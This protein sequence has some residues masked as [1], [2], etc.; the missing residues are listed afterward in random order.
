MRL[1]RRAGSLFVLV[2]LLC[3]LAKAMQVP[4][5]SVIVVDQTNAVVPG[6]TVVLTSTEDQGAAMFVTDS[7]GAVQFPV[8]SGTYAL[9]VKARGFAPV[10]KRVYVGAQAQSERVVLPVGA[11]GGVEVT[12]IA[13]PM[14]VQSANDERL[15]DRDE[16]TISPSRPVPTGLAPRMKVKL[17]SE[18]Q[19]QKTYAVV[20][21]TGDELLSGM[22]DFAVKYGVKDAHFTGIGAV[23][24]ATVGWLD[25]SRKLYHRIDVKEQVEVLSMVGDVAMYNGKPVVHA[26]MVFGK[27]DG[28][29][30]GGHLWE[31]HVDPT[32]EV[33][34]TVDTM[35]LEKVP[36][37]ASGMKVID[38]TR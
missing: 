36:D 18:G 6:A 10:T 2:V 11:G 13:P 20:F 14:E 31:A 19:G 27:R 37:D 12:P 38:P 9:A 30:V 17:V 3:G 4:G 26:H 15:I 32:V 1:A 29:T 33:F 8:K 5:L 23:S 16:E 21:R 28:S 7:S 34:V 22:T 35:P 25:L 24:G